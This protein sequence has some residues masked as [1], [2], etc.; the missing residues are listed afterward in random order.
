MKRT[1]AAI[2]EYSPPW[3]PAEQAEV[4]PVRRAARPRSTAARAPRARLRR[5]GS[6]GARSPARAPPLDL[7]GWLAGRRPRRSGTRPAW[8][9]AAARE[10]GVLGRADGS[11]AIGQ[12]GWNRQPLGRP[13][14]LGGSPRPRAP[15]IPA[16]REPRH[17]LQ[18]AL[19][20]RD[21]A[22]SSNSSSV[23]AVSTI[24]P[25]Y[26]TAT[27]SQTWR[28]TAMLCAISSTVRPSL[29]RRSS[30]RLSTVACTET[31]S[32][33]TGSS[34]TS[35]SGSSASARAMLTRW[36][37]P[38]ENCRGWASS[39]RGPRPTSSSSSRQ[40]AS[41]ALARHHAWNR[42]SSPST[43]RTVMRGLSDAYGSWKTIWMRRRVARS[44]FAP[45]GAPAKRSSPAVGS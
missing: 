39:A 42:S 40:R 19:R 27:R 35:S 32:A 16:R 7:G 23:G 10:R 6:C 2:D 12:R 9:A 11:C 22:G 38:P 15:S 28:T 41:T 20:V 18:Q 26:I 14:G 5:S 31:S 25:R 43:W 1:T 17:R 30:S 36:R 29:A 44:R 8:S 4:R 37:W 21:G 13:I 24:R 34:A 3:M 45:S 33:E